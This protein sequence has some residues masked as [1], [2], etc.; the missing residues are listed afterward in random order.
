MSGGQLNNVSRAHPWY[1][2]DNTFDFRATRCICLPVQYMS[3]HFN[4]VHEITK[5]ELITRA[6]LY[7]SLH[8]VRL[9]D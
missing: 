8:S 4:T 5:Y 3:E 7:S 2:V 9:P 6:T 1:F